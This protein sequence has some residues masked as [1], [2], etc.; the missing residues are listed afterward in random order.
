[1]ML[2][3]DSGFEGRDG[4]GFRRVLACEEARRDVDV[5][6]ALQILDIRGGDGRTRRN[7]RVGKEDVQTAIVRER[8]VDDR[9]DR[10]L[11]CCIRDD[12]GALHVRVALRDGLLECGQVVVD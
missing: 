8:L 12:G 4:H 2:P 11:V 5:V 1:M 6:R 9:L 7:G 3:D 10:C